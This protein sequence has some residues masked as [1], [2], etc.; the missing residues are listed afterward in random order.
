M[1][2]KIFNDESDEMLLNIRNSF[3]F[4]S[5]NFDNRPQANF[6]RNPC[7]SARCREGFAGHLVITSATTRANTVKTLPITAI[8]RYSTVEQLACAQDN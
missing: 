3:L 6:V 1:Y 7:F 5:H 4:L 2:N 8:S